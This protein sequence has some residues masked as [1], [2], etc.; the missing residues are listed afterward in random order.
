MPI[1]VDHLIIGGGSAGCVLAA[2]LSENPAVNVVILEAGPDHRA[3]DV[4]TAIRSVSPIQVLTSSD[5]AAYR[6]DDLDAARTDQQ[7][8]VNLLRGRGVGGSSTVNGML[9]VRPE[10]DDLNQ[11]AAS[12]CVGWGWDE[13]LP[14]FNAVERDI[15]FGHEPFH[16]AEGPFPVWR[17]PLDGW[18]D[19]DLAARDALMD[20]GHPWQLDHNAPGSTGVSPYAANIDTTLGPIGERVS[21][22]TAYL[23]PARERTNLTIIADALVDRIVF[24]G[25]TAVGATYS[26]HGVDHAIEA[27]HVVLSAGSP[28][29]PS[30]LLRSG[31]GAAGHLAEFDINAIHE[32]AGVGAAV[33]DHPAFGIQFWFDPAKVKPAANGRH[34]CCF[35]RWS[36]GAERFNDIALI[37]GCHP[38]PNSRGLLMGHLQVTLWQPES[39]GTIRLASSSATAQPIVH[40]SMLSAPQDLTRLTA[41]VRHLLQIAGHPTL[42][43]LGGRMSYGR[44]GTPLPDG[45]SALS[46]LGDR[47]LADVVLN[48]AHDTQ[49]I[50]GGCRMGDPTDPTSVVD[51]DCRVIGVENLRVIDASVFPSCPRAN[52][53]FTTLALAA[54]MGHRIATD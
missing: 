3:A 53:H 36:S 6:W 24:D 31:I 27:Q 32:L 34:T 52:T 39:V 17:P 26:R 50:V 41:A 9:A 43:A 46:D 30:L 40:E 44:N 20:L 14:W 5:D 2:R 10:A 45:L 16:G 25:R 15:E 21:A 48:E 49:H 12:G 47:E 33:A 11:W 28:H 22:N 37:A 7:E 38:E 19:L 51:P 4:P 29:S 8:A 13:M 1:T 54:R 18:S 23:E 42:T 35:A